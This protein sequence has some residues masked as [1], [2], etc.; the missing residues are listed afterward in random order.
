MCMLPAPSLISSSLLL[1]HNT[2]TCVSPLYEY[3][4]RYILQRRVLLTEEEVLYL[5]YD[6]L[7]LLEDF[8]KKNICLRSLSP[9]H[10][11]LDY[12]GYILLTGMGYA[13]LNAM[14]TS[15]CK[16]TTGSYYYMAPEVLFSDQTFEEYGYLADMY[17]LGVLIYE[18][19]YGCLPF[20]TNIDQEY[21]TRM[22]NVPC[23]SP[24]QSLGRHLLPFSPQAQLEMSRRPS[25]YSSL[26]APH[27]LVLL[28]STPSKRPSAA[29]LLNYP[30]YSWIDQND[31]LLRKG[32]QLLSLVTLS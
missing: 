27:P 11:L 3:D 23:L 24:P 19:L 13:S 4:L 32:K 6:I 31:I 25:S 15:G 2:I 16:G 8:Q 12:N 20:G 21:L 30:W 18:C 14:D 22:M 10:L 7:L 29:Q 1:S 9:E 28:Q 5:S 17:S 26:A